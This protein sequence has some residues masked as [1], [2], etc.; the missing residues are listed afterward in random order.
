MLRLSL[1]DG[2]SLVIWLANV[3]L[4]S[5]RDC[6]SLVTWL[7]LVSCFCDRNSLVIWFV[8]VIHLRDCDSFVLWL[9]IAIRFRDFNSLILN[10][11]CWADLLILLLMIDPC[12][13][14]L[15]AIVVQ[16]FS[17]RDCDPPCDCNSLDRSCC[18]DCHSLFKC[19]T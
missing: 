4:L 5:F 3:L 11:I 8:I 9:A 10:V 2:D 7:A 13:C 19:S 18:R 16:L 1:R 15:L 14:D 6:D 12:N 17:F